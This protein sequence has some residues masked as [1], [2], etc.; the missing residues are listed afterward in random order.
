MGGGERAMVRRLSVTEVLR[1]LVGGGLMLWTPTLSAQGTDSL[2]ADAD[3]RWEE[4]L[5]TSEEATGLALVGEVPC[6]HASAANQ[7][8]QIPQP[9]ENPSQDVYRKVLDNQPFVRQWLEPLA[10]LSENSEQGFGL[11]WTPSRPG[12]VT[13]QAKP[14]KFFDALSPNLQDM[15]L[16]KGVSGGGGDFKARLPVGDETTAEL[17]RQEGGSSFIIHFSRSF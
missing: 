5:Q 6:P 11:Q 16:S 15:E 10:N 1:C 7:D 2:F 8:D 4:E 9:E 12:Q 13:V 3:L 17:S 14:L